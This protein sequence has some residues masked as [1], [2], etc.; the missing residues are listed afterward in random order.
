MTAAQPPIAGVDPISAHLWMDTWLLPPS[1]SCESRCFEHLCASAGGRLC[2]P[3]ACFFRPLE[4]W[5]PLSEIQQAPRH[6]QC[7]LCLQRACQ[8]QSRESSSDLPQIHPAG[9]QLSGGARE[10]RLPKQNHPRL[11]LFFL[12][13]LHI[14][15]SSCKKK[16]KRQRTFL[17]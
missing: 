4:A 6:Q 8:T 15:M 1:G 14:Q 7:G 3:S 12:K 17:P 16:E 9:G 2:P 5:V 10:G 11:S 13:R